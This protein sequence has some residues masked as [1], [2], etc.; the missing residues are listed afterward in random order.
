ML[1]TTPLANVARHAATTTLLALFGL[2]GWSNLPGP[3][4][5]QADSD[6]FRPL[7]SILLFPADCCH[8]TVG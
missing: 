1:R 7:I 2:M 6:L 4:L 3:P 8:G 5:A